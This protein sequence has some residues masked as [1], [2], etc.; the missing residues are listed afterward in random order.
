MCGRFTNRPRVGNVKNT[1][2]GVVE[3][4]PEAAE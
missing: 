1:D 2:A 3:P 4:L